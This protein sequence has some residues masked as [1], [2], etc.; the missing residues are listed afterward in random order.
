MCTLHTRRRP[1]FLTAKREEVRPQTHRS[2]ALSLF[3]LQTLQAPP[4]ALPTAWTQSVSGLWFNEGDGV[5]VVGSKERW[6]SRRGPSTHVLLSY[7]RV[8]K[9]LA[10]IQ[11]VEFEVEGL[12]GEQHQEQR[13]NQCDQ[14]PDSSEELYDSTIN[15]YHR[16]LQLITERKR[17]LHNFRLYCL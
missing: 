11:C 13:N 9:L 12:E 10:K 15:C 5:S 16:Y 7:L 8:R 14:F 6:S 3:S 2:V 4:F 1:C 17:T